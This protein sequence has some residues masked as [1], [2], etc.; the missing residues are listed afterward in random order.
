M[1]IQRKI[2]ALLILIGLF[3]AFLYS[4][5]LVVSFFGPTIPANIVMAVRITYIAVLVV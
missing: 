2:G 5:M 1:A 3:I 4:I